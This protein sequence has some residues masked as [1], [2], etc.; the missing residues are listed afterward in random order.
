MLP[1]AMFNSLSENARL[2]TLFESPVTAISREFQDVGTP[3][4]PRVMEV[5]KI[6]INDLPHPPAYSAVISTVPLP[7]LGLM[8]LSNSGLH[9]NYP[10]WNAIHA[11]SCA[12]ALRVGMR[13]TTAW[14]RGLPVPITGGESFTDLT[15]RNM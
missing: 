5:M 11:L 6:S 1:Y 7:C 4:D 2:N 12:P 10:Q 15:I 14:W 9:Q 13:F 8:D 3:D